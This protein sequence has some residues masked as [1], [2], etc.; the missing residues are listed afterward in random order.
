M[1]KHK[2]PYFE[3]ESESLDSIL[4]VRKPDETVIVG[5]CTLGE[6]GDGTPEVY[7]YSCCH[8]YNLGIASNPCEDEEDE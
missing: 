8:L 7:S 1:K 6:E 3:A 4:F 5:M 2:C